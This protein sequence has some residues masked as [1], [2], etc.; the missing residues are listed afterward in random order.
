MTTDEIDIFE[1][2]RCKPEYSIE[3]STLYFGRCNHWHGYNLGQLTDIAYNTL[4]I[5][6][7]NL[8]N[9]SN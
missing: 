4:D 3:D 5:L 9:D 2:C 6:N 1:E 7:G 8:N